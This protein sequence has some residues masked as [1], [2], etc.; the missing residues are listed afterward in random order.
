MIIKFLGQNWRGKKSFGDRVGPRR[1]G[2][3]RQG[4]GRASEKT[5]TGVLKKAINLKHYLLELTA[6]NAFVWHEQ[7]SRR[8]VLVHII[9]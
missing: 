7:N 8:T 1:A 4:L 3:E 5:T 6:T 9:D 2:E